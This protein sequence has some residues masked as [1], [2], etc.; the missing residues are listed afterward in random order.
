[1]TCPIAYIWSLK[2]L[3]IFVPPRIKLLVPQDRYGTIDLRQWLWTRFPR[4]IDDGSINSL[5]KYIGRSLLCGRV[6]TYTVHDMFD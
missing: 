6:H 2:P 5:S 1:M 3:G 4:Y